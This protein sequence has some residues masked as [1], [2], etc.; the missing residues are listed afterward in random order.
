MFICSFVHE[1]WQFLNTVPIGLH[2]NE[3]PGPSLCLIIIN[4][5]YL[6]SMF[7]IKQ[8]IYI[9]LLNYELQKIMD[10]HNITIPRNSL[11]LYFV[12]THFRKK[13]SDLLHTVQIF[14]FSIDLC[15]LPYLWFSQEKEKNVKIYPPSHWRLLIKFILY[16][17]KKNVSQPFPL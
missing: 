8:L 16:T 12:M 1:K 15:C 3:F 7:T 14:T 6:S 17:R 4:Y 10:C 5:L 11:I 13:Y 9:I 2:H